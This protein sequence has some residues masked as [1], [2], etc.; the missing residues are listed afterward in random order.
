LWGI[1]QG[2]NVG[3]ILGYLSHYFLMSLEV[4]GFSR[5]KLSVLQS[6]MIKAM[7]E[8]AEGQSMDLDFET[9][10]KVESSRYLEMIGKK[11]GALIGFS[12]F[13]GAVLGQSDHA[14]SESLRAFGRKL[15][16]TM[17]IRDDLVGV[18]GGSKESGKETAK[19]VMRRKKTFPFFKALQMLSGENLK[20]L[21][22]HFEGNQEAD[23]QTVE[24]LVAIM[25]REGVRESCEK[26]ANHLMEDLF[27][28]LRALKIPIGKLS[29]LESFSRYA[30]DSIGT[31][32]QAPSQT[33]A[34]H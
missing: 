32:R 34:R 7:L 21:L 10:T 24:R 1:G 17:Q 11:T 19:D 25:E 22:Q 28:S 2:I 6:E 13:G 9:D 23:P 29:A 20:L 12:T 33:V 15:G 5:D 26:E 3:L 8:V 27:T 16:V 30:F 14:L 31:L 4:I 18:W